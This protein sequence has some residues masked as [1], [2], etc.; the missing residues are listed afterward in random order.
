MTSPTA[1]QKPVGFRSFTRSQAQRTFSVSLSLCFATLTLA[2][3]ALPLQLHAAPVTLTRQSKLMPLI[4]AAFALVSVDDFFSLSTQTSESELSGLGSGRSSGRSSF[5]IRRPSSAQ[6][7]L[8][9]PDL[10]E[11]AQQLVDDWDYS[12]LAY[13]R[14]TREELGEFYQELFSFIGT[15]E[16]DQLRLAFPSLSQAYS[17]SASF[18]EFDAAHNTYYEGEIAEVIALMLGRLQVKA[19]PQMASRILQEYQAE[20]PRQAWIFQKKMGI[21]LLNRYAALLTLTDERSKPQVQA[22]D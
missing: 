22:G 16:V 8:R 9:I 12:P 2:Q 7:F 11:A 20:L 15:K 6:E 17:Y 3:T 21:S 19:T 4:S 5:S 10:T 1:C 13:E 14:C 18:Q